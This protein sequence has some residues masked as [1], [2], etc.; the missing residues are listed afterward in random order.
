MNPTTSRKLII[1]HQN[2]PHA[3]PENN[4]ASD[5]LLV[6]FIYFF[7]FL[8]A[9]SPL[10]C[11]NKKRKMKITLFDNLLYFFFIRVIQLFN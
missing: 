1:D 10:H 2:Y 3:S 5:L 9:Q 8:E 7:L 11:S 6:S 4:G